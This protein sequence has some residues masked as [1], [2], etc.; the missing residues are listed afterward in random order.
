MIDA[1]TAAAGG[2]SGAREMRHFILRFLVVVLGAVAPAALAD[3]R[4]WMP[5]AA[6]RAELIGRKLTGIYPSRVPWSEEISADGTTDYVERGIRS[7]GRWTLKGPV[8]C[9]TY[10]VP[11]AG[12]C[13]RMIKLGSNC[14]ELYVEREV[15]LD[16]PPATDEV[17]WNGR[18][19][20]A[21]ERP[22]C[23]DSV[24]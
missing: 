21:T 20:R 15:P 16:R 4:I 18:M 17:G 24:S 22:T 12:G 6:I 5:E 8:F 9:F 2:A 1:L 11:L 19:W 3:E 10:D 13:F 23:E 7:V 14:Y